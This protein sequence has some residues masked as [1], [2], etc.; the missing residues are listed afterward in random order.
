MT[1]YTDTYGTI[2]TMRLLLL[3]YGSDLMVTDSY[4]YIY[5]WH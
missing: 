1:W 3:L 4:A 2:T 5:I